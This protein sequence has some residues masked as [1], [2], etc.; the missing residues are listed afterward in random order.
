MPEI[1]IATI[2]GLKNVRRPDIIIRHADGT[3]HATNVGW[4][5]ADEQPVK[6]EVEAMNNPWT[7][8]QRMTMKFVPYDR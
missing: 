2:G 3:R 7:Y 8:G 5:Y 4:I 6:R 1:V